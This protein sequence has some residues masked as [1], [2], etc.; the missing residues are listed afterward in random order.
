MRSRPPCGAGVPL[1]AVAGVDGRCASRVPRLHRTAYL[2]RRGPKGEQDDRRSTAGVSTA[3]RRGG[4]RAFAPRRRAPRGAAPRERWAAR[5]GKHVTTRRVA[6]PVARR[7]GNAARIDRIP[8]LARSMDKGVRTG[9]MVGFFKD[10][11]RSDHP[12]EGRHPLSLSLPS[13]L[14]CAAWRSSVVE[15]EARHLAKGDPLVRRLRAPPHEGGT[16]MSI[17]VCIGCS[18]AC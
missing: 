12:A 1:P 9:R 6:G 8:R 10:F 16:A 11:T 3:G 15:P 14:L 7:P 18:F 2:A 5:R 17:V 4:G 13:T